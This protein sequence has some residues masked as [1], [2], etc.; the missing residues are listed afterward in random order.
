MNLE[1]SI[2]AAFREGPVPFLIS[3][4]RLGYLVKG[5][6]LDPL[7]AGRVADLVVKVALLPLDERRPLVGIWI[8]PVRLATHKPRPA[9]RD[10]LHIKAIRRHLA[11]YVNAA[12]GDHR[13]VGWRWQ[14]A[15][16]FARTNRGQD[17][18]HLARWKG[19]PECGW[20]WF[21]G[22]LSTSAEACG[23]ELKEKLLR[24]EKN[25]SW[26]EELARRLLDELPGWERAPDPQLRLP[27]VAP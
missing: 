14:V 3:L 23:L 27:M 26:I 20:R 15:G 21:S 7:N 10:P 5:A 9:T 11:T 16:S 1:H 6:K 13:T 12:L 8:K 18:P 24:G 25:V 4:D 17:E 19:M 22:S 2:E